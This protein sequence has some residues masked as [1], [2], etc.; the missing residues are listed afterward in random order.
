MIEL[1]STEPPDTDTNVCRENITS[2][3]VLND[4]IE[5]DRFFREYLERNRP[6]VLGSHFTEGWRARREWVLLNEDQHQ[7]IPHVD[8]LKHHFGMYVTFGNNN[9]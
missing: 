8:Y 3:P 6:C 1:A 4:V 9:T 2:F 7:Y 5:Y